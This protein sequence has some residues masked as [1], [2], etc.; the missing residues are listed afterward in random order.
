MVNLFSLFQCLFTALDEDEA[1]KLF[2]GMVDALVFLPPDQVQE[3][4][5][6]L[7]WH[8]PDD[9]QGDAL[10]DLREYFDTTYVSDSLRTIRRPGT[11]RT[12]LRFRRTA[13]LFPVYTWNVYAETLAN[14]QRTNNIRESWN[15]WF[16]QLVGNQH[17]SF[18]LA[19]EA[20]QQDQ[21]FVANELLKSSHGRQ[22]RKRVGRD[23]NLLQQRLHNLCVAYRDGM[24]T[25]K[26][27]LTAI[28]HNIRH[29]H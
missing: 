21:A 29:Y 28:G 14:E 17:P 26:D 11:A 15:S 6:Y 22:R 24:K 9:G 12:V 7:R 13:P 20:M 4:L 23:T 10:R 2:C 19:V 5:Q 27:T 8:V 18:W 16:Q 1:V 3:G 25:M